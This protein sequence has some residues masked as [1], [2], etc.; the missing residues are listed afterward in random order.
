MG[1]KLYIIIIA[2]TSLTQVAMSQSKNE[3]EE[4]IKISEFPEMAQ[5]L[6]KQ[7]PE[8][9]KRFKFY[10]EI[11]G[12]K[13]SFEVKFKYKKKLYSLEFSIIGTI[14]DLEVVTK[15]RDIQNPIKNK[16]TKY[17]KNSFTKYRFIK[18]QRQYVYTTKMTA[19]QFVK[20]I[21][22]QDPFTNS[23]FEI[24][25]EVKNSKTRNIREFT[26]DHEGK[27]LTERI[28]EPTSY[29]HVLY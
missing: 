2:V 10:K 20:G 7:L 3:K 1:F 8:Q 26:F 23:N 18:I 24:I 6:I 21:F 14:Q 25:A 28:L 15:F 17:Y 19:L 5:N 11:D 29:E 12:S 4:R 27:F 13:N 16:I 9:C 22:S